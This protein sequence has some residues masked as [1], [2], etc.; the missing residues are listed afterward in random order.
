MEGA[1]AMWAETDGRRR[2]G[3]IIPKGAEGKYKTQKFGGD[4]IA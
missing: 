3:I 4:G 2:G 1:H